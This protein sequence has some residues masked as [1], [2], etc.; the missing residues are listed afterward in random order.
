[1]YF[2]P[3]RRV[4]L[5][6]TLAVTLVLPGIAHIRL[7]AAASGLA[8]LVVAA[9]LSAIQFGA[10]FVEP[11]GRA[12]IFSGLAFAL[13]WLVSLVA[14]RSVARLVRLVD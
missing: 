3:S 12:A 2:H 10:P 6:A 14:A 9:G 5:V 7:G 1:M 13:G 8:F 11:N 4:V